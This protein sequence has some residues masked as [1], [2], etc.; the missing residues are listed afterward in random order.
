MTNSTLQA[1]FES[2]KQKRA[3]YVTRM[4]DARQRNRS[5]IERIW[6][7]E[8]KILDEQYRQLKTQQVGETQANRQT[9]QPSA[10]KQRKLMQLEHQIQYVE[11]KIGIHKNRGESQAAQEQV[12]L[13]HQLR[14]QRENLL[15]RSSGSTGAVASNQQKLKAIN[16]DLAHA[17]RM[18]KEYQKYNSPKAQQWIDRKN[19]LIAQKNQ[20]T[21]NATSTPRPSNFPNADEIIRAQAVNKQV[22]VLDLEIVHA[23]KMIREYKKYNSPKANQWIDR[24]QELLAR[25]AQITGKPVSTGG[26]LTAKGI[27]KRLRLITLEVRHADKMI[28]EYQRYNSPKQ[29]EWLAKRKHL[30]AEKLQLEER[31]GDDATVV[32]TQPLVSDGNTGGAGTSGAN[33]TSV[34]SEFE[35]TIAQKYYHDRVYTQE[36]AYKEI[37]ESLI[38]QAQYSELADA[39]ETLYDVSNTSTL[40]PK[41]TTINTPFIRDCFKIKVSH[42]RLEGY[43][44]NDAIFNTGFPADFDKIIDRINPHVGHAPKLKYYKYLAHRD[45]I[46]LIPVDRSIS[47]HNSQFAAAKLRNIIVKDVTIRSIGSL[48]GLF[49]SDGAFENIHMK[50]ISIET[51]SQHQIAI[52]G[53]LSG[54]LDV[55][56]KTG[57]PIHV[58]L[59]PLRLAGG[60][61]IYITHF[62]RDSSYQ[63]ETIDTK[64]SDVVLTDNRQKM[65]KRGTYYADFDIDDFFDAMKRADPS[66]NIHT[67]I[68]AAAEQAGSIAKVIA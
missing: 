36:H 34:V 15:G 40:P 31:S 2:I 39:K 9:Y 62:S 33:G 59:L 30:L 50:N 47:R 63:Y 10:E 11:R 46:Q 4:K 64:N 57:T 52:L 24:K 61:N 5:D 21:G 12:V 25:R 23:E 13:L 49:A 16:A 37:I 54:V 17:D 19:Q 60:N 56:S 6:Y 45:A 55:S 32:V 41:G 14:Q 65:T 8:I 22:R 38:N 27:K 66:T 3:L 48:Q 1:K 53:L 18:I 35:K 44:I 28:A 7:N 68:K 43:T 58:N 20:L 26:D 42:A 67:R 51:R 29:H